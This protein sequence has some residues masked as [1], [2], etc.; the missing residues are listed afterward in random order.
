MAKY[1][2]SAP[3]TECSEWQRQLR[4]AQLTQLDAIAHLALGFSQVYAVLA[5]LGVVAEPN[6]SP[7]TSLQNQWSMRVS[8]L[9]QGLPQHNS[10]TLNY[11]WVKHE[12]LHTAAD[13]HAQLTTAD[14]V[15]LESARKAL[16]TMTDDDGI[17]AALFEL[18]PAH[19]AVKRWR[20][21]LTRR[22][23]AIVQMRLEIFK[24]RQ[25]LADGSGRDA[26][27]EGWRFEM[28]IPTTEERLQRDRNGNAGGHEWWVVPGVEAKGPSDH[29]DTGGVR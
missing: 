2:T 15:S 7:N 12:Y 14:K 20:A 9:I 23:R 18:P 8:P 5:R 21:E 19:F 24:L 13:L 4:T 22:K 27:K 17:A 26:L 29:A 11:T 16:Q 25:A 28:R 3:E 10:P 1:Y 6:L